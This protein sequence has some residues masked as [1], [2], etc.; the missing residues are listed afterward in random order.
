MNIL[1][2]RDVPAREHVIHRQSRSSLR[3]SLG[4]A[5]DARQAENQPRSGAL[6]ASGG[7]SDNKEKSCRRSWRLLI[8][9]GHKSAA[10]GSPSRPCHLA[11]MPVRYMV[12]CGPYPTEGP[13]RADS[14]S[15]VLPPARVP[16]PPW[17]HASTVIQ[18]RQPSASLA[19]T[20][21]VR[22]RRCGL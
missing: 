18:W 2:I 10:R 4:R 14:G 1:P 6:A 17:R 3:G 16:V 21:L 15:Q 5:T 13:R 9:N 11:S 8:E 20:S 19:S 12:R 7:G 22:Q